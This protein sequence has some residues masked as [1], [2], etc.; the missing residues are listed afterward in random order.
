MPRGRLWIQLESLD[1]LLPGASQIRAVARALLLNTVA[2]VGLSPRVRRDHEDDPDAPIWQLFDDPDADGLGLR[3]RDAR[4][5]LDRLLAAQRREP[6]PALEDLFPAL[7]PLA[8]RLALSALDRQLLGLLLVRDL[9]PIFTRALDAVLEGRTFQLERLLAR[10]TGVT[11]AVVSAALSAN[12]R[13]VALGL[14]DG[15]SGLRSVEA[16]EVDH[17]LRRIVESGLASIDD[18]FATAI[19]AHRSRGSPSAACRDWLRAQPAALQR[20]RGRHRGPMRAMAT[21]HRSRRLQRPAVA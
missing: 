14:V 7:A 11:P 16:Y 10:W 20:P 18:F 6:I 1:P 2:A 15:G 4:K 8:D 5:Q 13:L 3:R 21:P 19:R 17:R 12:G 9:D